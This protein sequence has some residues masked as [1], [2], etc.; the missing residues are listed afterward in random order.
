MARG[1]KT[2]RHAQSCDCDLPPA[3]LIDRSPSSGAEE[4]PRAAGS[5]PTTEPWPGH[6]RP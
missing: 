1:A 4:R 5:G 3:E 2:G 6:Q